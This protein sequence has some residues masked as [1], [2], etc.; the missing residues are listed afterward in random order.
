[1][2]KDKLVT[3][4][5]LVNVILPAAPEPP[6]AETATSRMPLRLF[7]LPPASKV[8]EP[9]APAPEP[10]VSMLSDVIPPVVFDFE[11]ASKLTLPPDLPA[12]VAVVVIFPPLPMILPP[13]PEAPVTL[14]EPTVIGPGSGG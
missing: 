5:A 10:L 4:W 3:G 9:L 2:L 14:T 6:I 11:K 7:V 1:M 8:T 13:V 12:T